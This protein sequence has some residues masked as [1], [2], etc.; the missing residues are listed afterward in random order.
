MKCIPGQSVFDCF[1]QAEL[2]SRI[3]APVDPASDGE[4]HAATRQ[5]RHCYKAFGILE[6]TVIGVDEFLNGAA[7][8]N[9]IAKSMPSGRSESHNTAQSNPVRSDICTSFMIYSFAILVSASQLPAMI[10]ATPPTAGADH[11]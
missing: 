6:Y 2:H 8:L 9:L 11:W 5:L 7:N 3:V 1:G 4:I 10:A